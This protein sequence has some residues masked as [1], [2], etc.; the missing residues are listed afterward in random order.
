MM[1]CFYSTAEIGD[2]DELADRDYLRLN[3][4]LPYQDK[5]QD[6]VMDFHRRHL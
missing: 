1:R 2:Y 4:L 3:T 6:H 5:V